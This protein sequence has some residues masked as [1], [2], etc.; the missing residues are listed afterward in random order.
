MSIV[1]KPF[2]FGLMAGF[3]TITALQPVSATMEAD[4]AIPVQEL[5]RLSWPH[6]TEDQRDMVDLIAR[7]M[8]E[9]Q[10]S[11]EQR[12]RIGGRPDARYEAL[13]EWRKTPFRGMALRDLGLGVN[14]AM[15]QSV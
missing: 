4:K 2:V 11:P 1:R 10:L 15:L 13:S 14:E 5:A 9:N 3:L 12:I 8:Y 7:D 6:L